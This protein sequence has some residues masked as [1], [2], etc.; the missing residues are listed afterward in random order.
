MKFTIFL[1]EILIM[2]INA[3]SVGGQ[4]QTDINHTKNNFADHWQYVGIAIEEPNYCVWGASPIL[5]SDGKV[6]LFAER[7]TGSKVEPGW[8]THGEIAHYVSDGP[9]GPFRFSDVS[10]A[11]T[12]NDTWDKVSVHNPAIHKVGDQ[13]V[14]LYIG[15]NNGNQPPHPAN[16]QIGMAISKSL[17][18]P[19]KKVGKDGLILSPPHNP[20]YWNYKA[21]NGVNNPAFLVHPNGG[22]FLYYKSS[23]GKSSK[24]G[25]AIAENLEGP[26]IQFPFPVTQNEQSV[27]DGYAFLLNG[28][29]CLLTTDNHGLIK[30]GGG[31]LWK[32]ADGIHFEEKEQGFYPVNEYLG[33]E[34]LKNAVNHYSGNIIKFERP[35]ILMIDNKPAYLY[36]TSGYHFFGGKSPVNYVMKYV[37]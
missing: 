33:E 28:K 17:Y 36:V 29:Y 18:G 13:Y 1:T 6:H 35:Q 21:G 8:R 32:S 30:K 14:L 10:L 27:E 24:M 25:L 4:T 7:W 12:S 23:D 31:I 15:N 34:K 9:E 5:D 37:K 3:I 22:F 2:L 20:E 11:P 19:W 16:Q 26:Y